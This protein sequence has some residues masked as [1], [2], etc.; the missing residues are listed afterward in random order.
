MRQRS[1][2]IGFDHREVDAFVVACHSLRRQMSREIPMSGIVLEDLQARGLYTRPMERQGNRLIDVLSKRADYD[3][4]ISTEFAISRFLVKELAREGLAL[5]MDADMLARGDIC[6]LF[7][8]CE[9]NAGKAIYCVKHDYRPA[10]GTKM[11]GQKQVAYPRKNWSSVFAI[12]CD[13]PANK[14]L[15]VAMVNSLPGRDLHRFCW[16]DDSEIGDLGPEWNWLIGH[17]NPASVDPMLAHF[18][19]GVPSMAGH[20]NDAYANEWRDELNAAAIGALGFGS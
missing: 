6:Q 1:I 18:T 17:K 20:E 12:D 9:R 3:G 2:W 15:T 4:A 13:A 16:L 19:A 8:E 10:E 5:F 11:D 7:D 14:V